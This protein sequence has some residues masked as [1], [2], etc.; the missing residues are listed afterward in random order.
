MKNLIHIEQEFEKLDNL[1]GLIYFNI[2]CSNGEI[3]KLESELLSEIQCNIL[4]LEK[5]QMINS[6]KILKQLLR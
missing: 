5:I 1:K 4:N 3:T 6:K 2:Q